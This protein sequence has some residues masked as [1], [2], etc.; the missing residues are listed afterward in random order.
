MKAIFKKWVTAYFSYLGN[1]VVEAGKYLYKLAFN[2]GISFIIMPP[3]AFAVSL[4]MG[5][6]GIVDT[7]TAVNQLQQ[8]F[9]PHTPWYVY[10]I[11]MLAV[12]L[13]EECW[14]RYLVLDCL[15]MRWLKLP[16]WLA[17]IMSSASFGVAHLANG[18]WL[19]TLPQIVGAGFLGL[20]LA[21]I[22]RT[23]GL[24]M[25]ILTHG[26]YNFIICLLTYLS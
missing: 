24:H 12:G 20:W 23:Q 19:V 14:F 21:R 22:Y 16:Y 1:R 3:I 9:E 17:L 25:A 26:C 10:L 4:I 7:G 15:F 6:C 2:V 13:Y 11:T 8:L 18:P 5:W